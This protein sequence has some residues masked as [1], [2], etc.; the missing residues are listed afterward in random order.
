[1]DM[2]YQSPAQAGLASAPPHTGDRLLHLDALRALALFGVILMNVPAVTM[3]VSARQI[4]AT[5]TPLDI[6]VAATE[7]LLVQGKARACFAFL[8]GYG[9]ALAL[10][11]AGGA[12]GVGAHMRRMAVLFGFGLVNQWLLFF[13][14]ILTHYALLGAALPLVRT[15]S[16]R[17]LLG[18]GAALLLVPPLASG[19]Y[20][21]AT[22]APVPPLRPGEGARLIADGHAAYSSAS[23]GRVVVFNMGFQLRSYAA[24]TA[25]R[26]EYDLALLGLFLAGL[27]AARHRLLTEPA[28]HAPL[29]RRIA[30]WCLPVGFALGACYAARPF[31]LLPGRLAGLG[32]VGF[33]GLSVLS[34]GIMAAVTLGFARGAYRLQ[35]WLAPAGRMTLTNY[36]I[37][38]GIATSAFCGFGMGLLGQ[39]N[40]TAM[41]GFALALCAGLAVFSRA[42]LRRFRHGPAEWLLRRLA[43]APS[44]S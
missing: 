31:G 20:V 13:G 12:A 37:A 11:R 19:L 36:L 44:G 29:L 16:D 33:A 23:Y 10:E 30:L 28:A 41:T 22:G 24:D 38:G 7:M 27:V 2:L 8:F 18:W 35:A 34:F 39:L 9:F 26:L 17:R 4:M 6:A 14:D 5:A 43:R 1:M 15:W 32:V 25:H 42:W 40:M 3:I 21:A